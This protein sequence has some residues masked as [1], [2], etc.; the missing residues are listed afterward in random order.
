MRSITLARCFVVGFWCRR[1]PRARPSP[2]YSA[3]LAI[4]ENF[5]GATFFLKLEWFKYEADIDVDSRQARS[6]GI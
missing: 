6:P 3:R 5:T 2:F 1:T 4:A